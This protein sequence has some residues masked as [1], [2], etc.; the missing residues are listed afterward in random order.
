MILLQAL[1]GAMKQY[2]TLSPQTACMFVTVDE[3]AGKILAMSRVPKVSTA[4]SRY[5]NFLWSFANS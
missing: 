4:S 1:D 5:R 3:E 2:M